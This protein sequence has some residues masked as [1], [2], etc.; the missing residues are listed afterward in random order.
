MATYG[1]AREHSRPQAVAGSSDRRAPSSRSAWRMITEITGASPGLAPGPDEGRQ[2]HEA[3]PRLHGQQQRGWPVVRQARPKLMP[4]ASSTSTQVPAPKHRER[5]PTRDARHPHADH[6]GQTGSPPTTRPWSDPPKLLIHNL[7][8]KIP[9]SEILGGNHREPQD[10][11]LGELRWL[12][13]GS[14]QAPP[15]D[16]LSREAR[17]F[18]GRAHRLDV[19]LLRA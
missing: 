15:I 6:R 9:S 17:L 11:V 16:G 8:R 19:V 12:S 7:L 4:S 1:A 2:D 10:E 5:P 3:A 18:P 13:L 14:R